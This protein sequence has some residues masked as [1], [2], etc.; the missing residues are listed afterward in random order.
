MRDQKSGG[1]G[2]TAALLLFQLTAFVT[3]WLCVLWLSFQNDVAGVANYSY[4]LAIFAPLSLL[5]A[6][7]SRTYLLST[8]SLADPE[9]RGV[10]LLLLITGCGVAF[11]IGLVEGAVLLAMAVYLAKITEF[12]FDVPIAAK[13]RN[14]HAGKLSL[15]ALT[16][17][18]AIGAAVALV[19]FSQNLTVGLLGVSLLFVVCAWGRGFFQL[20][21]PR[22]F[23]VTLSRLL[24]LSLTAL[25]FSV[26]FNIPRYLLGSNDQDGT[27]AIFTISSFLLTAL[28]VINNAVCQAGLPGWA[29][30]VQQ[31]ERRGLII[32]LAKSVAVAV[33]LY[34]ALQLFQLPVLYDLFWQAHNNLQRLDP[35]YPDVYRW[36]LLLAIG[37][38][39]FSFANYLLICTQQHK[40]LLGITV[41][42]AAVTALFSYAG[43][44]YSGF[45]AVLFVLS[46][47]GL[48]HFA[49]CGV[50]FHRAVRTV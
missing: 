47:S 21:V 10:R 18:L 7:P 25:M 22:N 26:Y 23:T 2:T 19:W 15:L 45:I 28:L 49:M 11:M 13:L 32:S 8:Q 31:G 20:T 41:M 1:H 34:V 24:P 40:P 36:V 42:N 9:V 3:P 5:L 37:P 29:R 35:A 6:S 30:A 43:L 46:L 50:L 33:L 48:V 16:K 38:L 12:A 27:L 4:L 14:R 44:I 39:L 17:V